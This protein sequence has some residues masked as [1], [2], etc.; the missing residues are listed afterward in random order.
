MAEYKTIASMVFTDKGPA[1]KDIF[2][3][4]FL[5][6]YQQIKNGVDVSNEAAID[7]LKGFPEQLDLNSTLLRFNYNHFGMDSIGRLKNNFNFRFSLGNI[8][9]LLSSPKLKNNPQIKKSLIQAFEKKPYS[10]S[11]YST[12]GAIA[13]EIVRWRNYWAHNDGF[14]NAS[15]ALVL[16]SNIALILKIYPDHLQEKINGFDDYAE[17]IN[18]K[19]LE[20]ILEILGVGPNQNIDDE[21]KAY[22]QAENSH[23]Q[24]IQESSIPDDVDLQLSGIS[25][26]TLEIIE[27]V[28]QLNS[29]FNK[30]EDRID[31]LSVQ[32]S[33]ISNH[34]QF[35]KISN[36][37]LVEEMRFRSEPGMGDIDNFNEELFQSEFSEE[38]EINNGEIESSSKDS[39]HEIAY[40]TNAEVLDNLMELRIKIKSEMKK[41]YADFQNWHNILM[42]PLSKQ[43]VYFKINTKD[44]FKNDEIFQHYYLSSQ[45]TGKLLDQP[46]LEEK[47]E[48]AKKYMDEQLEIYWEPIKELINK[49]APLN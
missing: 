26:D 5:D 27:K 1:I 47:K 24:Q 32:I 38:I 45:I 33:N 18:S 17:F 20:S 28:D 4:L 16:Q 34:P 36:S 2:A 39:E 10:I 3:T 40:L 14:K 48:L 41:K 30:I 49:R 42:Q 19:F 6:I 35:S 29:N 9:E 22:L 21:I 8:S 31:V 23:N 43:L 11:Q 46:N 44:D 15:E 25:Y 37:Q 12:Y 7:E 13:E